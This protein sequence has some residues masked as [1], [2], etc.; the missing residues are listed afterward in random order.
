MVKPGVTLILDEPCVALQP[1]LAALAPVFVFKR[2]AGFLATR[3]VAAAEELHD[4]LETGNV[5][6]PYVFVAASFGGFAALAYA[7]RYPATLAGLVLVDSSH[8]DQ[9]VMALAA[10]PS[11]ELAIPAVA[12][13][14]QY[15]RGFGP[16]WDEGCAEIRRITS[17]GEVPLI[18]LAA[19]SPDMPPGLSEETRRKL[20]HGWH[21]LQRR[22]AALS[23]R[24]ELRIVPGSGHNIVAAAPEA[25]LA[26]VQ[27]KLNPG[28]M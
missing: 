12:T 16:V 18:A 20:T 19:G 1:R 15:L 2:R 24:G 3:P 26:A 27:E 23:T 10:I 11:E 17:L 13:F 21:E 9:G 5:A 4:A 22:H 6:P 28:S 7:A 14:A 8:P 25:I